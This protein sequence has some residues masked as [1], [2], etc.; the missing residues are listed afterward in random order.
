MSDRFTRVFTRVVSAHVAPDAPPLLGACA[1]EGR[2][3]LVPAAGARGPAS[4]HAGG[5]TRVM[6]SDRA[7]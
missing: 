7:C 5:V 6:A 4:Q 2:R 1:V 3:V